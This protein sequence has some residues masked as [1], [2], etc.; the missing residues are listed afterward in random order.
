VIA[1]PATLTRSAQGTFEG[2]WRG[3]SRFWFESVTLSQLRLF[4]SLLGLL[5]FAIYLTRGPD[6]ELLFSDQG[7]LPAAL[8]R[9]VMPGGHRPSLLLWFPGT[10][11]VWGAH[12][13]LL[14]SLLALGLGL[15]P[16]AAALVAFVLHVS[17]L[18]RDM[19]AAY[20]ADQ[21]ATFFLLYLCLAAAAPHPGS[22]SAALRSAGYRLCQIQVCVV[23]GYSGLAKLKGVH[24][25][26]GEALWDVLANAQLARYD[27]SW[28]AAFPLLIV[29]ATYL[30]LL[31]EIYF[32]VLVWIP[33]L[34]YAV[35]G[36]GVALHIGMA[37]ALDIA[38]FAALMIASY[39]LFLED[40]DAERLE[41]LW[42]R[43]TRPHLR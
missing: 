36:I 29:G 17:F 38:F 7:L 22:L 19:A 34:R 1:L 13:A 37:L 32:P 35:L 14:A 11:F 24:W 21:I 39:A 16:R 42:T 25:W 12:V 8:V 43:W 26:R 9:E 3:W 41:S 2:A 20:G 27:F 10:A 18:H 15:L 6:L 4:R 31:F 30:T 5:L 28:M 40:A 23:Y 33:R